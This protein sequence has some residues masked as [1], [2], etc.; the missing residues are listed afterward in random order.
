MAYTQAQLDALIA[1]RA[2]GKLRITQGDKTVVY[3]DGAALD[4][5]IAQAK[6]DVQAAA[7]LAGPRR[8]YPEYHRGYS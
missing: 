6:A 1:L 3:Q 7:G 2:S 8:R 4:A 5:A